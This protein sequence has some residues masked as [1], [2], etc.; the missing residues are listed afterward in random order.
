[1][2]GWLHQR[3]K[4]PR[5]QGDSTGGAADLRPRI[6]ERVA[7]RIRAKLVGPDGTS[8]NVII[9]DQ[10]KSGVALDGVDGI[11]IGQQ[12]LLVLPGGELREITIRWVVG[13]Q[14]GARFIA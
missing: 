10:S 7:S 3:S 9:T 12:L 13:G 8:R 6:E 1:M 11:G 5:R 14:A 2:V 4:A